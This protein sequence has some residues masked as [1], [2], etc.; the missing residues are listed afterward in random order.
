[1]KWINFFLLVLCCLGIG[2]LIFFKGTPKAAE[3]K[4]IVE[5]MVLPARPV[6]YFEDEPQKEKDTPKETFQQQLDRLRR[7]AYSLTPTE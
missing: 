3:V 1:M 2:W 6:P 5:E 7:L 4:A